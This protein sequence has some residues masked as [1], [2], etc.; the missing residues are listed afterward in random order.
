[1][2]TVRPLNGDDVEAYR[3]IRLEGLEFAPDA[4]A[5]ILEREQA[6]SREDFSHRLRSGRTLGAFAGDALLGVVGLVVAAGEKERHKGTLVGMY[7][8]RSAR[9][10]G[11]GQALIE[12]LLAA[13]VGEVE[14]VNLA[15]TEDN[16]AAQR[17]YERCGFSAYGLEQ[18]SLRYRG[19]YFNEILMARFLQ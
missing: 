19:R 15:V 2:L 14:Q 7:V 13:A 11:V 18:R 8:S 1:M 16:V 12:A 6:F 4:F 10:G 3:A 17:L 9:G 5:S